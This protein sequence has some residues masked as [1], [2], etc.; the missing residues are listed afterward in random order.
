MDNI[1]HFTVFTLSELED[2]MLVRHTYFTLALAVYFLIILLNGIL[3]ATI[4]LEKSLH[5]P[6]YIFLCSLCING[7]FGT[8]GFYP[9]FMYDLI[10]D[11]HVISY[12]GCSLQFF[13]IYTSAMCE[14][15]TLTVMSYDRYV[16]ICRPL[17]YHSVM[18]NN[19]LMK[20]LLF[21]WL[22]PVFSTST[23]LL[24][25]NQLSLCGSHIDKLYCDNLSMVKLSCGPTINNNSYGFFGLALYVS[26]VILIIA[27]YIKLIIACVKS[28][29]SKIK[30]MHTCLPHLLSLI[31][32]TIALLFDV[33]YVRYASKDFPQSLRN[34]MALE[35]LI[36][37]PVF[38]PL[39]YGLKLTEVR[40]RAFR[41]VKVKGMD[42]FNIKMR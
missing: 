4:L 3:I 10:S 32:F 16:A 28:T 9:K 34:F 6:M 13:V 12:G 5:E 20:L 36:I 39:I 30:F 7:L 42:L 17:D 11:T 33:M 31:N 23:A 27:S 29:E 2:S 41:A 25:T 35:F 15:T 22:L 8:T 40:K 26:L 14:F 37:P 38:N 18:T 1:S 24:L 21:S 19:T